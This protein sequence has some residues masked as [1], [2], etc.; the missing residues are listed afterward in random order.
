MRTLYLNDLALPTDR[1]EGPFLLSSVDWFS[2]PKVAT[3]LTERKSSDGAFD[4]AARDVRYGSRTAGFSGYVRGSE[5]EMTEAFAQLGALA[6]RD[7][8]V[9]ARFDFDGTD[10]FRWAMLEL[11]LPERLSA[12][13]TEFSGVLIFTDPYRYSTFAQEFDLTGGATRGAL[14]EVLEEPLDDGSNA[15]SLNA[16]V[17]TNSGN[18]TAFPTIT[19][20]GDFPDGVVLMGSDGSQIVYTGPLLMSSPLTLDCRRRVA[21]VNGTGR[22]EFLSSADWFEV[23]AGGSLGISLQVKEN[24]VGWARVTARDTW[25]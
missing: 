4:V 6:G 18:A 22:G 3:E 20:T 11:S 21:L 9:R 24:T 12:G 10:T 1:F 16:C 2:T 17:V 13:A 19:V 7:R 23:P 25:I 5:A 15:L 8:L 14:E